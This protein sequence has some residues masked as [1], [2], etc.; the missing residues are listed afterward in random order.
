VDASTICILLYQAPKRILLLN[1]Q[2][3]TLR[4]KVSQEKLESQTALSV[5]AIHSKYGLMGY[6]YTFQRKTVGAAQRLV[7]LSEA[8]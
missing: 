1:G 5:S 3:Y 8:Q 4:R 7:H 6:R 2:D